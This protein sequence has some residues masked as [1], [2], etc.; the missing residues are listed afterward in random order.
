MLHMN[1]TSKSIG[2]VLSGGGSKGI[3][4]AGALQ[5]LTEQGIEPTCIAGTSAGSIV[6]GLYAFGKTPKEILD[7]YIERFEYLFD[8]YS[9]VKS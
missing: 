2:I 9:N 1:L 8:T 3:A 5:Y 7:K 4:H 6:G